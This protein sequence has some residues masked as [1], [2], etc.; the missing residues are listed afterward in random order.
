MPSAAFHG[1]NM[2][3]S[4]I[5][6][7][8]STEH[9]DFD[10]YDFTERMTELKYCTNPVFMNKKLFRIEHKAGEIALICT[11]RCA[12]WAHDSLPPTHP[13]LLSGEA[14]GRLQSSVP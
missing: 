2:E 5:I 9:F 6:S 10:Q 3:N 7:Y 14:A 12:D 8:S 13:D 11:R 1:T 4:D